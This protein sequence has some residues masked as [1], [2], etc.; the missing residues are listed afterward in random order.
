MPD[1]VTFVSAGEPCHAWHFR[2]RGDD[3]LVEDRRPCVVMAHGFGATKDS[4][5]AQYAE[6]MSAAG[7]DVLAFDYRGFGANPQTRRTTV[8]PRAQQ[9]DYHAAIAYARSIDGV[10]PARII[11]WGVSLSSGHVMAVA[12]ADATV[13]GVIAVTP[14]VDGL[15][16]MR[17]AAMRAP[18]P[19]ARMGLAGIRDVVAALR[20][21]PRVTIPVV[22]K[23]GATAVISA[24]G[25]LAGYAAM[26]GPTA[27][28]AVPAAS[29]LRVAGYR[30]HR[31]AA[32]VRCPVLVQIADND[33][34]APPAP[35]LK[36]AFR[37][38]AD[39]RH[40]PCDHFDVYPG[41]TWFAHVVAHQ[42]HFLRRNFAPQSP[43]APVAPL[44]V[45]S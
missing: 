45:T 8:H 20:R 17:A 42:L 3:F 24:P 10:D 26:A 9:A 5:L 6:A 29:A 12:A 39:V 22:G 30:P 15:T 25:A 7:L 4:G 13:A 33:L 34:T 14:A 40:Y 35:A 36:A 21:R 27:V 2:G 32:A 28:N 44:V 19:A 11:V 18:L 16:A 31:R 1:E 23:P 41:G 43:Y 37:C 38:R